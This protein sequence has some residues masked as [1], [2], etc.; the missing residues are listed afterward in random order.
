MIRHAQLATNT[1]VLIEIRRLAPPRRCAKL[2]RCSAYSIAP[3][4][5]AKEKDHRG[6]ADLHGDQ[7]DIFGPS[8]F[9]VGR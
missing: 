7:F 8:R 5:S 6:I 1:S 2:V 3:L 4:T 9:G